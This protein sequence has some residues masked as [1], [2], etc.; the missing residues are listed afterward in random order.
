RLTMEVWT[1]GTTT[2][3]EAVNQAAQL[4]TEQLAPFVSYSRAA[5]EEQEESQ[6]SIPAELS[7]MPVEQLSLSVRTLNSLRRGGI[8]T[9]G[10]IVAKGEKGLMNLRNF[11]QK[12]KQE[13]EERLISLG[14]SL[15]PQ[16]KAEEEQIAEPEPA[17]EKMSA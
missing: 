10:E 6:L 16:V 13:V 15:A 14:L 7:I 5:P 17:A 1:D 9:V 8:T 12:S 4:L 11:G 2:A 3:A